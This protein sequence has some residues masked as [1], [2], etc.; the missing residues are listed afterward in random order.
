MLKLRLSIDHRGRVVAV[1]PVG[2]A[3]RAFLAAAR[4]HLIAKWRY[5]PAT[6]DGRAVCLV[7]VDHACASSST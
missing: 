6:E 4:R 7:H 5:K 2:R 3:D 1:E